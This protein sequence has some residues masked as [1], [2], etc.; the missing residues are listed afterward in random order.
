MPIQLNA[1]ERTIFFSLNQA[2]APIVDLW[3][4]IAFRAVMTADRLGI[5]AALSESPATATDLAARLPADP[6]ALGVLL[7]ALAPLG[8]LE[9]REGR[10]SNT[11]MTARWLTAAGR[12]NWAPY[13]RFW[14]D[15][16]ASLWQAPEAA[17]RAG[18]PAVNLY[19]WLAGQPETSRHFQEGMVAIAAAVERELLGRLKFIGQVR[20]LLDVGAGHGSYSIAFCR[21]CPQLTVTLFDVAHA[22]E[23]A[24]SQV[25]QAGLSQRI[26]F[27]AGDFLADDLPPGYD[28]V[29][30]FNI[31]HGFSAA[32][33]Q[34]LLSKAAASLRPGGKVVVLEQLAGAGSSRANRAINGLL[35]FSFFLTL[36]GQVY[37][38]EELSAWLQCAGFG[39]IRR[40]P[41]RMSAGSSL[42]VGQK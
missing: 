33:N 31:L 40:H 29:F 25:I 8:Y 42:M 30:L 35:A 38:V 10:Y 21:Q 7:D 15:V 32:Q 9:C 36:G 23:T 20:K 24:R 39:H 6:R 5:F 14:D 28:V 11:P 22:L 1:L 12:A 3:S 27:I 13:L 18:A 26:D 34:T 16:L 41:L 4:A 37:S 19:A 2:P 17:V